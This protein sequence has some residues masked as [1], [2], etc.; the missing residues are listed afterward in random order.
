[1]NAVTPMYFDDLDTWLAHLESAH[2]VGIDMGLSRINQVKEKLELKFKVPVIIVGGTN[3][4]GSTC[5]F[6]ESIYANAGYKVA[7]HTSPHLSV[8]NERA[9]INLENLSSETLLEYFRLVEQARSSISPEVTL[10]YF[11]FTTLAIMLCFSV[12]PVDV[13]ILE[14]GLGGR[15]DAVNIID[16]DCSIVTSIDIDHQHFLGD[17]REKIGFEKAGIYRAGKPAIC[18]DPMPPKSLVDY[19]KSI[20][21]DFWQPGIDFNFQGDQQ[22]WAWNGR[23]KRFSGLGYPALRGANQLLNASGV[24]AALCALRDKLPVSVQAIRNGFAMVEL[25]GRF[26]IIPGQPTIVL[27][28][29]HNPHASATLSKSLDKMGYFPYTYAIFGV[30]QDKDINAVIKPMLEIVDF[31]YCVDLPTPRAASAEH[32][33]HRLRE[34]G[35]KDSDISGVEVFNSP[36]TAYEKSLNKVSQNDRIV[37]FGSFF[38]VSGVLDYRKNKKH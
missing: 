10:T 32:L 24:L 33:A 36:A 11:E 13:V 1:M 28:V 27:D 22:Q 7:C 4:K 9:R 5:A 20:G 30:M 35:V 19:A 25:P 3:G 8:F 37:V 31:W 15:L 12:A 29:A 23:G 38:T 34:L 21:A 17:T 16:A 2:P 14:V 18:A 26:Q 6:L